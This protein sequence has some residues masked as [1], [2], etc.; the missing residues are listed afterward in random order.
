[1]QHMI[2]KTQYFGDSLVVKE[3]II[4]ETGETIPMY[5]TPLAHFPGCKYDEDTDEFILEGNH[6]ATIPTQ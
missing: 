2:L 3:G 1:M 6:N 5:S 4:K